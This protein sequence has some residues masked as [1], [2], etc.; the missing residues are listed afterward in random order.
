MIV[1]N[2]WGRSREHRFTAE[3]IVH[4]CGAHQTNEEAWQAAERRFAYNNKWWWRRLWRWWKYNHASRYE[5]LVTKLDENG[6]EQVVGG[7]VGGFDDDYDACIFAAS[8]YLEGRTRN[9]FYGKGGTGKHP[10]SRSCPK[11]V[12]MFEEAAAWLNSCHR[13]VHKKLAKR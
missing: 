6:K 13:V 3:E 7:G 12:A 8:G 5:S 10:Y 1:R 2:R 9:H 4:A 11:C